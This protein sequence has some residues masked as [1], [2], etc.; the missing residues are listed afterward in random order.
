MSSAPVI[1][2]SFRNIRRI[3]RKARA[4]TLLNIPR[5]V[6]I[7]VNESWILITVVTLQE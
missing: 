1:R 3:D 2:G 4:L 6:N 7:G 5:H